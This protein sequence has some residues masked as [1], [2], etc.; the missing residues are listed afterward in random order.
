MDDTPEQ[1]PNAKTKR[2]E[3]LKKLYTSAA[4]TAQWLRIS[5]KDAKQKG[6]EVL[7]QAL[8]KAHAPAHEDKV[9]LRKLFAEYDVQFSINLPD[10]DTLLFPPDPPEKLIPASPSFTAQWLRKAAEQAAKQESG[11]LSWS[12]KGPNAG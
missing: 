7:A 10:A 4:L 9:R 5:A 6:S 3:S 8:R 1:K 2:I 12:T 11:S